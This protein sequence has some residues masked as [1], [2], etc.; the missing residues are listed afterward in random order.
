M[1]VRNIRVLA[2]KS[3][4]YSSSK[5]WNK[6]RYK[7]LLEKLEKNGKLCKAETAELHKLEKK[8]KV[9]KKSVIKGTKYNNKGE[10]E[11]VEIRNIKKS[12]KRNV[13]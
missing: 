12:N 2:G 7:V 5:A 6:R 3:I 9:H 8:L 10:K 13:K 11:N 1:L 4:H